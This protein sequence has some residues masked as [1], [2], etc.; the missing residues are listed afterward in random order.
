MEKGIKIVLAAILF[1]LNTAVFAQSTES[2]EERSVFI[3]LGAS[4]GQYID[5]RYKLVDDVWTR[6]YEH[7]AYGIILPG[8]G[9]KINQRF[10]VGF[11][12]GIEAGENRYQ[13]TPRPIFYGQYNFF[14]NEKFNIFIEP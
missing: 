9:Y 7:K 11:N 14:H 3:E 4:V 2:N 5:G 6:R 8:I 13:F 10:N 12:L 1:M